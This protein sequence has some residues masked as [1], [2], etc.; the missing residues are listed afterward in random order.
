MGSLPQSPTLQRKSL[1]LETNGYKSRF[2]FT[3]FK[4]GPC[5][6]IYCLSTHYSLPTPLPCAF[7]TMSRGVLFGL[8]DLTGYEHLI[9]FPNTKYD[10]PPDLT[11]VEGR[12]V[13]T[14]SCVLCYVRLPCAPSRPPSRANPPPPR[15]NPFALSRI[16]TTPMSRWSSRGRRRWKDSPGTRR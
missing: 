8:P 4:N 9:K 6:K 2:A 5:C 7:L 14:V 16:V 10:E 1:I 11:F 15:A 13:A 3:Q 12:Y